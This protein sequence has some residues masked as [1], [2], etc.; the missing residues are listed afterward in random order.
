MCVSVDPPKRGEV[1]VR[2]LTPIFQVRKLMRGEIN[3]PDVTQQLSSRAGTRTYLFVCSKACHIPA[4][5]EI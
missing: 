3:L 1:G 4:S 2:M 5:L